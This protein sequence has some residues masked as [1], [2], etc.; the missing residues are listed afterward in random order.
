[1]NTVI[2]RWMLSCVV[3]LAAASGLNAQ[4]YAQ[5][6]GHK[7]PMIQR[8]VIPGAQ[9]R[10]GHLAYDDTSGRL[11]VAAQ[12]SNSLE[13]LDSGGMKIAQSIKD[14]PDASGVVL[15][16]E[17]RRLAVACGDGTVHVFK[18]DQSGQLSP[19][20]TIQL[21]GEADNLI[22]DAKNKRVW[23]GH[24][25]NV[26]ALDLDKDQPAMTTQVPDFPEGMA[27]EPDGNRLFVNIAKRGEIAVV[28]R[29]T[30]KVVETWALKDAKSNY[31]MSLDATNKRLMVT[32]SEPARF[33][34]LDTNG[35]KE[36][37]RLE[38]PGDA[39]DLW[40]DAPGK[41]AY[42]S[43]GGG[44]GKVAMILQDTP[45]KYSVE[46]LEDTMAGASTSVLLGDKRRLIVTAPTLGDQPTFVYFFLIPP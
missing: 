33:I 6:A 21:R 18:V 5:F 35:G 10:L 15:V 2:S 36:V 29:E 1:M 23:V 38:I 31:A 30:G 11:Y 46:H 27:I 42:A 39:D 13:V 37:A 45:D 24:G 16:K 19:E 8:S 25:K 32:T 41:R 4:T 40:Y 20:R 7:L 43:C 34:A 12:R 28:N 26:S 22:Y 14:L 3:L 17:S 44:G 9:G